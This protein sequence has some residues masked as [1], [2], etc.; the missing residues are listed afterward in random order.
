VGNVVGSFF[1][2]PFLIA[3]GFWYLY[4]ATHML[5]PEEKPN[6]SKI[7]VFIAASY[8]IFII[9]YFSSFE[10]IYYGAVIS[11]LFVYFFGLACLIFIAYQAD[12]IPAFFL[13][14]LIVSLLLIIP[15]SF[16]FLIFL[17]AFLDFFGIDT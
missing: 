16:V 1:I 3:Y 2:S 12:M 8:F 14:K 17:P 9:Y 5:S 10:E 13:D 11:N 7:L 4:S 6:V 15:S